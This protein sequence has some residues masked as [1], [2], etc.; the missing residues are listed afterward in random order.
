M[1]PMSALAT[2]LEQAEAHCDL[3]QRLELVPSSALYRGVFF[4]S[5]ESVLDE[6]GILHRYRELFPERTSTVLWYPTRQFLLHLVVAG[7][8]LK[9]PA[10]VYEGMSEIGRLLVRSL[11]REPQKLL[12]QGMIGHRQSTNTSSWEL[13]FPSER[14]AILEMADEY[15][16]I[17]SYLLGAAHGTFEAIDMRV[18]VEVQLDGPFRGRHILR[19]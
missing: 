1:V 11:S 6:A 12:L 7:A 19:W 16:Y 5:I 10:R 17:D 14:S 8:L 13:S 3:R 2:L 9:G 18:E 4:R 15:T